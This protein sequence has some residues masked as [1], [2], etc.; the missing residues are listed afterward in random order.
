M[1]RV[2]CRTLRDGNP[3][4]AMMPIDQARRRH[5]RHWASV[6]VLS[7]LA[8]WPQTARA[9]AAIGPWGAI[10]GLRDDTDA[11][12][13]NKP[14]G[15]WYVTPIH[16]VLRA[17]DGKVIVTGTGRIGQDSCNGTTQR[18]LRRDVRA[19][20]RR[21][22]RRRRRRDRCWCSPSTNRRAT[23]TSATS[24]I[25]AGTSRWPTD[26]F[27]TWAAPTIRGCLPI[28]SPELGLDYSRVFDPNTD[29]FTRIDAPMKGG[30]AES[31]GMKWYPTNRLLPDG[32]VLIDG[33]L[34][35]VGG[36]AGRQ[37]K[38]FPRDLR[39]RRLGCGS[40]CRSLHG[41][42]SARRHPG[43]HQ[44]RRQGLHAR[45]LVAEA[46]SRCQ[47]RRPGADGRADRQPGDM[48][49]FNHEPGPSAASR[50]IRTPK[51][52][53]AQSQRSRQSRRVDLR[54]AARRPE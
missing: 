44:R 31:P 53:A 23:T 42:E 2:R 40:D 51:R 10:A 11:H 21:A 34:S 48:W 43:H 29:T 20:S 39:S 24:C 38:S 37:G 46:G 26:A 16:V 45:L 3:R 17:R 27:S 12:A 30:P 14:A 25:A 4:G 36:W 35:L 32:R 33:W 6:A 19:R 18:R 7:L 52:H 54:D 8:L 47:G 5:L 15:G 1:G 28:S 41:A 49:L 22:R 9:A 13:G 50:I